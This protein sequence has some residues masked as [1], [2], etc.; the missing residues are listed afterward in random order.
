MGMNVS[1]L[2]DNC[3]WF[4]YVMELQSHKKERNNCKRDNNN[5]KVA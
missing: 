3:K 1:R 2:S 5:K 4:I